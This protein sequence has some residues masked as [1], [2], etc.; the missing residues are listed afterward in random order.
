MVSNIQLPQSEFS[1]ERQAVILF[2]GVAVLRVA[3]AHVSL[4]Q[5]VR[6]IV[7]NAVSLA[8]AVGLLPSV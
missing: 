8:L 7:R 6:G 5:R 3:C 4:V 1:S 2:I